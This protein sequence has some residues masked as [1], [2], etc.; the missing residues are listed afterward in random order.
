MGR[1]S[2]ALTVAGVALGCGRVSFDDRVDAG[3]RSGV[4]DD[5]GDDAPR[6]PFCDGVSATLCTDFTNGSAG[7]SSDLQ[8]NGSYVID[9]TGGPPPSGAMIVTTTV[10]ASPAQV[11]L[12]EGFPTPTTSMH[13][14]FDVRIDVAGA[15]V[16]ALGLAVFDGATLSHGVEY[17]YDPTGALTNLEEIIDPDVGA[18]TFGN[19][20]V[21]GFA[22]QEWHRVSVAIS[23]GS[24]W[25]VIVAID[26]TQ[27]PPHDLLDATNGVT[28]FSMGVSYLGDTSTPWVVRISN[29]VV[30]V[31]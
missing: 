9:P 3:G 1:L 21:P 22:V 31:Q 17:V 2:A 18:S 23:I 8:T 14:S 26:G 5:G 24:P 12:L 4:I 28:T 25:T 6:G 29:V 30:D 15:G 16:P 27:A 11:R 20:P 7:W 19:T 10:A 13:Y